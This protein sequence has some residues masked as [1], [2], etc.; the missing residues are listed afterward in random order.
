M[1]PLLC[2]V[3]C[4]SA[5]F[6]RCG[7]SKDTAGSWIKLVRRFLPRRSRKGVR[8]RRRK[9][10][11]R[12]RRKRKRRRRRRRGRRKSENGNGLDLPPLHVLNV[13]G[14]GHSPVHDRT[15]PPMMNEVVGTDMP[16]LTPTTEGQKLTERIE[17]SQD[18]G[19]TPQQTIEKKILSLQS[20]SSTVAVTTLSLRNLPS[21]ERQSVLSSPPPKTQQQIVGDHSLSFFILKANSQIK[22]HLQ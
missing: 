4:S 14:P 22:P 6:R 10:R 5:S 1:C 12:R 17:D 20:R 7:G 15:C 11:R 9:S 21:I 8:G 16:P 2:V 13:Q 19:R 3:T 18:R